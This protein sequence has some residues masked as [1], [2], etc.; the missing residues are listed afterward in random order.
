MLLSA[1]FLVPLTIPCCL[2]VMCADKADTTLQ[3]DANLGRISSYNDRVGMYLN[4]RYTEAIS[5]VMGQK[6]R[7]FTQA[8]TH[9]YICMYIYNAHG[10]SDDDIERRL[11]WWQFEQWYA[12]TQSSVW[13]LCRVCR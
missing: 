7:H 13:C 8:P 2:Y 9:I 1:L 11:V 5:H 10:G 6:V 4:H 12:L 3:Y